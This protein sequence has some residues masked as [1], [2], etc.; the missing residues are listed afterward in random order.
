MEGSPGGSPPFSSSLL[1]ITYKTEDEDEND[2]EDD[3]VTEVFDAFA[4]A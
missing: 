2:D 4:L 1:E 3:S